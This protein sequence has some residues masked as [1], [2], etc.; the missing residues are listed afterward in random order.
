LKRDLLSSKMGFEPFSLTLVRLK[1]GPAGT[2]L[3]GARGPLHLRPG[4]RDGI[5]CEKL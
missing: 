1:R 2:T 4:E 3:P 5:A